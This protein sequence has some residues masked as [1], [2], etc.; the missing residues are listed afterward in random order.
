MPTS[1]TDLQRNCQK[2][3]LD[4]KSVSTWTL[5][6]LWDLKQQQ[7]Q[8]QQLQLSNSNFKFT[9]GLFG[10]LRNWSFHKLGHSRKHK[11]SKNWMPKTYNIIEHFKYDEKYLKY[12]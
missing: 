5:I 1:G 2:W 10:Q 12:K 6:D 4:D 8:Q 3:F 9:R 7:E 11:T